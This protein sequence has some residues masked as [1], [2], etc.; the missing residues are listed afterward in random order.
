MRFSANAA[1]RKRVMDMAL[2]PMGGTAERSERAISPA[3]RGRWSDLRA[4]PLA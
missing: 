3:N 2:T 4:A 1:F